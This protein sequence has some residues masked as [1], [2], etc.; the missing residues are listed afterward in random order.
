MKKLLG[1]GSF[2]R[3]SKSFSLLALK[4]YMAKRH[5][6]KKY[7]AIRAFTKEDLFELPSGVVSDGICFLIGF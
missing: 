1:K 6:T 4:V 5:G 2:A 7:F 3:V